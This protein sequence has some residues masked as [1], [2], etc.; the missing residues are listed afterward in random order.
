MI[1]Q[2]AHSDGEENIGSL[3][4]GTGSSEKPENM[5]ME[6]NRATVKK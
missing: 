3:F 1:I 6:D 2:L 4:Q 5:L